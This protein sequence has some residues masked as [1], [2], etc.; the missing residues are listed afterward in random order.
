[1]DFTPAFLM[2]M[3]VETLRAPRRGAAMILDFGFAPMVG[4][5][6]LLLMAVASTVLTHI[7]FAMMPPEAR[8]IWGAAM[9]SPIRTAML[10]W[11]VLLIS[12]HAIHKV[13]RKMGG[14]GSL[15]GA[16]VLVAWLQFILLCVQI[17]Q[18]VTQALVPPVSDML[19]ILGLVLFLWLM[20][21]FVAELH[22][23]TNLALTFFGIFLTVIVAAIVL[24]VI[25]AQLFGA[26][27]TGP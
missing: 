12:V 21:N 24:A 1:M 9:G 10:Q 18:L 4:W 23:F 3:V 2:R 13:G 20:T 26:P 19:G 14:T 5:M 27:A 17:A 25:F 7:S 16:V 6:A 15:N 8:E 22:G 11:V